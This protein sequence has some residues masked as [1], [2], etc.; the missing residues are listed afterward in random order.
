MNKK[1]QTRLIRILNSISNIT[2]FKLIIE[3]LVKSQKSWKF[4]YISNI[5]I[6]SSKDLVEIR[7][8]D[9]IKSSY[10]I[11]KTSHIF[12]TDEFKCENNTTT[13]VYI[14]NH[15]IFHL[16]KTKKVHWNCK[17]DEKTKTINKNWNLEFKIINQQI[18]LFVI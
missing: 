11:N 2:D 15:Q 3:K 7:C 14:S 1:H 16:I 13:V 17:I 4:V 6:E 12:Y 10:A 5:I 8:L 9:L 18:E